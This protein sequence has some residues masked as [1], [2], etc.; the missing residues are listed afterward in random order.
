MKLPWTG[1]LSG[2]IATLPMSLVMQILHRWPYPERDSLPPHQI[3]KQVAKQVGVSKHLD[4]R[5]LKAV[6]LANHFGFGAAMG[7]LYEL[8]WRRIP[9]HPVIKGSV[10]GLI[11]WS[12]SYLGWLPAANI[13]SPAT[14]HS[15][16]R[17]F[18]MIVAHLVWGI[19][20]ALLSAQLES[21]DD[22]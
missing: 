11:V 14:Q 22:L 19:S 7:G 1:I 9:I 4:K 6:T 17:N 3:T 2:I 15:N 12:I 21:E 10:W 16:R 20:L 8:L 18:I 13:L 5:Q